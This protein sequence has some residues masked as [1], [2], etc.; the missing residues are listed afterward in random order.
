[1][2]TSR[3]EVLE[4]MRAHSLAVQASVSLSNSPQAGVV[5]FVVTDDFEIFFDTL[6]TTRKIPNLRRNPGV[7]L[8]IGGLT[9][10]DERT[11]QYEG[12][13]DEPNGPDLERL[14]ER[15]FIRFPDGRDRQTWAGL[16]YVRARPR[17]IRFSDFNQTP[18][19]VVEFIFDSPCGVA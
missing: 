15:Y 12:V 16:T 10:G 19:E 4:F 17:W 9:D 3:T 6:A 5:G 1:M 18:P 2:P 14:K 13:A 7:A 11:V 8:V